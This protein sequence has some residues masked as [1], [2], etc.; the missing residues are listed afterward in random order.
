VWVLVLARAV[1]RLGAFTL[2]FLSVTLVASFGA[3]VVE[4]GYLLAAFGVATIPSRLVGG[5]LADRWGARA[6][7]VTGLVATAAAQLAVAAAPSL[8]LAALAVVALGL[9]FEL[10]EPASQAMLADATTDEQ[11]PVAFGLLA[12]AM[13]AAGMAAG[14]LGAVLAGLGLRWLF[15]V[16]SATCLACAGLVHRWLGD[17]VATPVPG[18]AW[19]DRRLRTM[20]ALGCVFAVVY[21][22]VGVALPLTVVARGL[23]VGDVG[24]LLTLSAATVAL[25]QPV[26]AG[27]PLARLD[28][29]AA[30]A[31]GYLLLG[32]GLVATGLAHGLLPLGAATVLWS[33]GDLVL[34]G[35]ATAVVAGL[36]PAGARGGYLATYGVSWG[37]AAVVGPLV[38]TRLFAA[39]GPVLLWSVLGAVSLG[40]AAAQPLVRRR[41][42]V[43][44]PPAGAVPPAPRRARR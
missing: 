18:Y 36:A 8:A 39:G 34:L 33:L 44:T 43:R 40:L 11:R 27:V 32:A 12:A 22:Q 3:S 5:W 16:D 41:V 25:A 10:Y 13:A 14:L 17:V 30:M 1:N 7:I 9:A 15:V 37:V 24:L 28:D 20:L 26:L 19:R 6:T 38:G 2:P 29:F 35:R 21:L 23:P 31:V 4:A 42:S